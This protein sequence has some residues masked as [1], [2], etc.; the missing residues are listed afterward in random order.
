MENKLKKKISIEEELKNEINN[1]IIESQTINDDVMESASRIEEYILSHIKDGE[2]VK[3]YNGGTQRKIR[4]KIDIFLKDRENVEDVRPKIYL[5]PTVTVN[6]HNFVNNKYFQ[7]YNKNHIINTDCDSLYL[8]GVGA[9]SAFTNIN[10]NYISIGFKP[11][12]KFYEDVPHEVNHIYQQYQERG[13]YSDAAKYA[14]ITTILR[15]DANEYKHK[16]ANLLYIINLSE[17]DSVIT[18]VYNYVKD[19][20]GKFEKPIDDIL[21]NTDAD[22]KILQAKKLYNEIKQN[23][24]T[25]YNIVIQE[26][27]YKTWNIFIRRIKNLIE[28]FEKKFA[29]VTKK[30]KNDFVLYE[31]HTFFSGNYNNFYLIK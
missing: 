24:E 18:S 19:E 6:C 2:I 22:N 25:Y 11:L 26:F 4:F 12:P 17:Q 14:N 13:T 5:Q 8:Q 16:V 15:T 23:K 20:Y 31:T 29:M 27:K 1:I 9:K 30:C 10:I 7:T 21:K 28:R 3:T